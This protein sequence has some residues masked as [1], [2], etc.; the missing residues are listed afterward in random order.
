M[1]L[2]FNDWCFPRSFL[3]KE[4]NSWFHDRW[5]A[6]QQIV[7]ERL[8]NDNSNEKYSRSY[9]KKKKEEIND[10]LDNS[11]WYSTRFII[12]IV[13]ISRILSRESSYFLIIIVTTIF[14]KHFDAV[15]FQSHFTLVS[16]SKSSRNLK[17]IVNK[18]KDN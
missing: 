11:F 15:H 16:N 1:C 9:D 2:N 3:E 12:F 7:L 10:I 6:S 4:R 18:L 17:Q 14:F 5:R 13:P 8:S